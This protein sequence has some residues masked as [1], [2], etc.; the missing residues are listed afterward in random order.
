MQAT[1]KKIKQ[2]CQLDL[3]NIK[4]YSYLMACTF[5]EAH[6]KAEPDL[7]DA[8]KGIEEAVAQELEKHLQKYLDR[9]IIS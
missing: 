3:T 7:P 6:N 9:A 1:I 2:S 4:Q 8:P 5:L